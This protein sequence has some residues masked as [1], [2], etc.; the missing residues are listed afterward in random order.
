[1]HFCSTVRKTRIVLVRTISLMIVFSVSS[2]FVRFLLFN[3]QRASPDELLVGCAIFELAARDSFYI[4]P[5]HQLPVNTFFQSFQQILPNLRLS[6][7]SC[8]RLDIYYQLSSLLSTLFSILFSLFAFLCTSCYF[9][10]FYS[11]FPTIKKP[12]QQC[13]LL[14]GKPFRILY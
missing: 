6:G 8:W 4:L 7:V 2:G 13:P 14:T 3:F 5:R 12:A 11:C 10:P 1:M 9:P